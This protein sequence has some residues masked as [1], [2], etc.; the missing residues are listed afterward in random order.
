MTIRLTKHFGINARRMP[1]ANNKMYLT[2]VAWYP[3][4]NHRLGYLYWSI[5][6]I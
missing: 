5:P 4:G 2:F 6:T 1:D 3:K